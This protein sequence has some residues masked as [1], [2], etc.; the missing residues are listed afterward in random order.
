[1]KK[2]RVLPSAMA[3]AL[4]L[5]GGI[6]MPALA[7]PEAELLPSDVVLAADDSNT[8][9]SG[10]VPFTLDA[11]VLDGGQQVVSLTLDT[12]DR[13]V[14]ESSLDADTFSVHAKGTSPFASLT[15][16]AGFDVDR[17]VT[18]ASLDS[19]GDIVIDL[20]HGFMVPGADTLGWSNEAGRNIQLDLEYTITQ[21]KP[22]A[23]ADS[24]SVEFAE[25]EQGALVDAEVDA[26]AAGASAGLNYRLFTPDTA[27]SSERPLVVW[28]HGGGEGGWAEAQ[29][30]ALPLLANRGALG[31]ITPEA[32]DI[33]G[34]AYVLAPQATDFWMNDAAMG[35]SA[36][37]KALI[38]DV[39]ATNN[40]DASRIYVAG[41]SNGGYMA[42]RLG[43]DY[44]DYFAAVVPV[45]PAVAYGSTTLLTD[46]ELAVLNDVPTWIVQATSD[47]VLPYETNGGHM[48]DI[49][50]NALLTTYPDVTAGGVTYP[51][52][53]SWIY[54]ANNDP[55]NADGQ[56]IWQWM[57]AQK[58]AEN[59]DR[60]IPFTLDAKV[61]DSGQ[62]VVSL[63]L[64]TS[65]W[66]VDGA[67]LSADTFSVH[68]KGTSPFASLTDVAGFDLD[69]EVTGASLNAD[70]D[71]VVELG[72]GFGVAGAET[73]GWST[74]VSRNIQLDLEYTITQ[75][76]AV[77]LADSTSVMFGGF[78]QGALVDAEVDAFAWGA[79]GDLK[80]RLFIPEE[81][82]AGRP[83]V[84][85]LH[86]GG[87]GGWAEAQD[88]ALPLLA[89]R[90]ALGF[91]TPESQDIFGGAYVLAP[92]AT[93][94]WFNDAEMGYSE[95]LKALIDD[96]VANHSIDPSRIYVVGA[97]NGGYMA[98]RL[99]SD[100]PDYFAAVVPIC[101]GVVS[102]GTTLLTDEELAVLNDVPTWIVQ[103]TT[104]DTLPFADN[105]G[106]MADIVPNATLTAY[107]D[108][109]WDG[110]TYPAHWSWIY[111][112][113]NDPVNEDG[114]HIWQWMAEQK[115]AEKPDIVVPFTLDA[116][117]LDGGQQV[118]SLTLETSDLDIDAASLAADTF[119]VNAKGT[120]PF[121]SLTDVAGFDMA[122]E[123]T[124]ASLNAD[125]D[126]VVDLG[127]GF[128][129]AGAET[130]GWSNSALRNVQLDL[131][132]T[133]TQNKPVLLSDTTSVTFS[134]FDQGKLVDAE[135]DA[136]GFG[137]AAGLNY[138]LFTPGTAETSERP[139]VVWLHGLGEGGWAEAQD[140]ALPLLANR[141]ALGFVT[142]EA[143]KI[144]GGAY[145]L[146]PQATDFWFN[147]SEM[148]YSA[149]LKALID[150]VVAKQNIDPSRIYVVGASNGGYMT[151]RLGSDYP[152]YFAA[153]VPICPGV[154]YNGK[155]LLTDAE[156]E[157]LREVPTWIVQATT[158]DTLP[159]EDNG[160]HM[161]DIVT[162]AI[163]T[164][165]PDVTWDGVT[166]PPHWS[167]I[168]VAN[169][170]PAKADGQHIWQWMAA[171]KLTDPVDPTPTDKPT[172]GPT[173]K[174]TGQP[175]GQPTTGPTQRPTTGPTSKPVPTKPAPTKPG[176]K[177]PLTGASVEET[178]FAAL[179]LVLAGGGLILVRRK[180]THS[181]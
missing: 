43:S 171:Q 163:L 108:V 37:L 95:K 55:V 126:I 54:V 120:S 23:L 159:F 22:I 172:T 173:D 19:E 86:G 36:Q 42:A 156:L 149:K 44:P 84:V 140:N 3:F 28:L 145:V 151:A 17:G 39:V 85:W 14:D 143:Q 91:A 158:D 80:Y 111:V 29:D 73:L 106:H 119:S 142:P 157:E 146:A 124:G 81:T 177:L 116:K 24:T 4:A 179:A 18:G 125:G 49:V 121:A 60:P 48:A 82:P 117:V 94:R 128:G 26:F 131:E 107:P 58:L 161:A 141:G 162:N 155:T 134:G 63:T 56:H 88:N 61:L 110:V 45:C 68:A 180:K 99:G 112:A 62:Q 47:D 97:S 92:Q 75:N 13:A 103:A 12:S 6:G 139:L 154:V 70:G 25:F 69:R 57:A 21:N 148:G 167:W 115:L 169:N 102:R 34:G 32:Q 105:G 122:R 152:D 109:T 132:Y 176:T 9:P 1:M 27:A 66:D 144:F 41:A 93:D 15:D 114:Q 130:L 76:E 164:A 96:V 77:A 38:D 53:F 100:Y 79:T 2:M 138:R 33:F 135:V 7:E 160:G 65:D 123:V 64:E 40:I 10:A 46:D 104:D 52:H 175:T 153:V 20:G 35:Y 174:P 98:A 59:P 83:L 71:V 181:E 165:Y 147:D 5:A 16:V 166:Y 67:D 51:P 11:Y 113:N 72:H 178:A 8:E 150:D 87:E 118:V 90:G 74:S 50:S 168:Y 137:A 129:V 133:I 89:N 30:N 31:F 136:F 78:E 170:A 127:H 101:P